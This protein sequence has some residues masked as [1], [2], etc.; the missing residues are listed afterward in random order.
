[1][2]TK[3]LAPFAK[4]ITTNQA[5]Q[6]ACP[7]RD[8]STFG[9]AALFAHTV[10]ISR[11]LAPLPTRAVRPSR[12]HLGVLLVRARVISA[13]GVSRC[14]GAFRPAVRPVPPATASCAASAA[15]AA[16]RMSVGGA[17]ALGVLPRTRTL[18][19]CV[20]RRGGAREVG[21]VGSARAGVAV[22]AH[23]SGVP[24][25]PLQAHW[26]G[27]HDQ[28][29]ARYGAGNCRTTVAQSWG[30]WSGPNALPVSCVW[31][32]IAPHCDS[33]TA[34]SLDSC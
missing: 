19:L 29:G 12:G 2:Q 18:S 1:M 27:V 6:A 22:Q 24:P 8:C 28:Q 13:R 20:G 15:T 3:D 21:W 11:V 4:F 25:Q 9:G 7:P 5:R 30:P 17:W 31:C 33:P 16:A 23:E 26:Q 32:V 34:R 10:L 14:T